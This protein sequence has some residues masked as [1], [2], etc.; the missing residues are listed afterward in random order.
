MNI[1]ANGHAVVVERGTTLASIAARLHKENIIRVPQAMLLYARFT[2]QARRIQA[3][4]YRILPGTTPT[5]FINLLVAGSV[6]QFPVTFIEGWNF[7]TLRSALAQQARLG[8]HITNMTDQQVM[9]ALGM[10]GVSPEGRF[11]PDTYL[12]IAASTD[13]ALLH[14]S[15]S[16]MTDFLKLAWP[17]R[18]KE[19][20]YSEVDEALVMASIIEKETGAASERR[21]IAGVFVRR[22]RLGMR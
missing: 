22:L 3:G 15:A 6:Q 12:Y 16:K 17:K 1:G 7:S 10:R 21:Q 20:P 9:A 2:D 11:F 8:Q 14:R 19:L 18:A 4:E 5:D 13:L